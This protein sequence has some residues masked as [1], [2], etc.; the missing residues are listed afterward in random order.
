M[1]QAIFAVASLAL[2]AKSAID[3]RKAARRVEREQEKRE[4][5]SAGLAEINN[6]KE[7]IRRIARERVA[8]ANAIAAGEARGASGDSAVESQIGGIRSTLGGDISTVNSQEFAGGQLSQINTN[9][10][11]VQSDAARS[12]SVG[13]IS[14]GIFQAAGGFDSIFDA[15][16]DTASD[17]SPISGTA[18]GLV[19]LNE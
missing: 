7:V 19:P 6:R 12:Q 5:I 11:N 8:R 10:A 1:P 4:N 9:I 2:T 17:Q 13:A 14:Q 3:Q 18:T 15:L 16:P